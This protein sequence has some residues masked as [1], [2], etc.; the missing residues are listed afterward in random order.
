MTSSPAS[1]PLNKSTTIL[2]AA[3]AGLFVSSLYYNQPMLGLLAKDF[4]T[5]A[6]GIGTI[7]VMTQVGYAAGMLFLAPLG[8]R[9]ERRGLIVIT[10]IVL[11]V[12]LALAAI[13]PGLGTMVAAS[14]AI[15]LLATV[16]QQV[17]PMAAHLAAD[18]Q[19]GQVV[20]QVMSGLLAGI[21]L[22]RTVSGVVSEF[23]SWRIM[24][25]GAAVLSL[26]MSLL[27]GIRLP[28]VSP[29]TGMSYPQ[30]LRS[31]ATLVRT[32]KTLRVSGL[33]QGLLFGCF[34]AFWA[35]LALFLEQPPL[36]A[37]SSIAGLLGIFG[38]M[39]VLAA[40]VIGR[41]IDNNG[42]GRI[43]ILGALAVLLSFVL[44][45]VFR[46]SWLG[47]IGGIIVM[48]IGLQIAMI[49]NQYRVYALDATARS[50]LNTVYMTTMFIGGALGT[51]VGSYA[52][53]RFGWT[54]ICVMGAVGSGLS[55]V[56]EFAGT[57]HP[58]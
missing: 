54:G 14:L 19:R 3:A 25:G 10:G 23:A 29:T 52:F 12:A 42:P 44:F 27:L 6:A 35:N 45:G 17:V 47:L 18:K 30:I 58:G 9:F 49:S 53:A 32:H 20:G 51:A 38:V 21:L 56:V 8:D 11:S 39:G 26:G 16:T 5:D 57:R 34:V 50:R 48:D 28:K 55:M 31:M 2:M 13:A 40:P 41:R 15:G 33:V 4:H 46:T 43:I 36:S 24:F 7:P 37:G 22:A 1:A